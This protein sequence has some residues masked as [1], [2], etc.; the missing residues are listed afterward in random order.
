[1]ILESN[2]FGQKL[3]HYKVAEEPTNVVTID[4][5][6]IYVGNTDDKS[7]KISVIDANTMK[8]SSITVGEWPIEIDG[9]LVIN[10][11]YVA[12][13]GSGTVSVINT[14]DNSV[15]KNITVGNRPIDIA[16]VSIN[17]DNTVYVA[18]FGS[19]TVSVINITDNSVYR[20]I[21]NITVGEWPRDIALSGLPNKALYVANF[22]SDTVSVINTTDNSVI[23]NITV[24]DGPS[25]MTADLDNNMLYVANFGMDVG[26][27]AGSDTVSV[28]NTTDNRVIKN[29][30][31]GDMD[32]GAPIIKNIAV[33]HSDNTV[34]VANSGSGTVSVINGK[35][36]KVAAGVSFDVSPFHGGRIE[37]NNVAIPTNQY[38]Y[39]DFRTQCKAE[40]NEG[41]QF[42]SWIENLE[43]NSSRTINAS[44]ALD[45]PLNV[46]S[47][48]PFVPKDTPETLTVTKFGNF[49][50]NFEKL[51]PA[52]PP[53]YLAT[54]FTVVVTAFV[55]SW[56]TPSF[57]EW[58]KAKK[59][60][61]KLDHYHKEVKRLY[62]DGKLDKNNIG[63]LDILR[64]NIT[65]EYTRGKINKEQ[66][67]KLIDDISI[68]YREIFKREI[69]SE[70]HKEKQLDEI[71]DNIEDAFV[72]GKI[73]E[74]HY[75]L[76]NKK[77]ESFVNTGE[78]K[79][80]EKKLEKTHDTKRSPI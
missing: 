71:K 23:K 56:L 15:I 63:G 76:L 62:K 70:E 36:H 10:T 61:K 54:L 45:F 41:F 34:Y 51:P 55:G 4:D 50:A 42:N 57:I 39:V 68:S 30:T 29:I 48:L 37:C 9:G 49:T 75:N 40:A 74:Q 58:R 17:E 6:I 44:T 64:N 26:S 31:V 43:G 60:G 19:D 73:S 22:G 66:F 69:L 7:N 21:K 46:L 33:D 38:F 25:Y 24:G 67:D 14:I 53:E 32:I 35:T 20:V 52:I 12:N 78:N 65:D 11:V 8:V 18:N 27:D 1:M 5:G 77:I 72:K 2:N 59:Q 79:T 47:A 13:F 3:P 16:A 80:G 28:I